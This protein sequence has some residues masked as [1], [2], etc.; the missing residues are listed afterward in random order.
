MH[1][2]ASAPC[3]TIII[4]PTKTVGT[5]KAITVAKYFT[6]HMSLTEI[7]YVC[8]CKHT[9]VPLAFNKIQGN[10]KRLTP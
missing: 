7:R 2:E 10:F 6:G 1:N 9:M 4:I 5:I 8:V 3:G